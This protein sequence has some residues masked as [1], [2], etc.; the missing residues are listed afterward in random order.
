VDVEEEMAPPVIV[1]AELFSRLEVREN[2]DAL[3]MSGRRLGEGD[4][5]VYRAR[6]GVTL[7]PLDVG[8]G[9]EASVLVQPQ[10][11]GF[12]G[13][14]SGSL[15]DPAVGIHQAKM[16]I[17]R[18]LHW[19]DVGRFEMVYG[20]H[21][22]IGSV[23][24]HET[25]RSFDGARV[26]GAIGDSG[27]YVDAFATMLREGSALDATNPSYA[28]DV[29]FL[30]LYSGFGPALYEGL[31]ADAY[32]LL[33]IAA[34]SRDG[35]MPQDHTA[36]EATL[37]LRV[38]HQIG[39]VK[40]R[41]EAGLQIGE[42]AAG[43]NDVTAYHADAD[44]M[45][46]VVPMLSLGIGGLYA[47]GDDPTTSDLEGWNQL[48]PTAHKFL[49]LMD[50]MGARTNVASLVGK[51][52]AKPM[53]DLS[54]ALDLHVFSRPETSGG[55]DGYTG[56]ESDLWAKV[57]LGEGL[58]LSALYGLFVPNDTGPFVEDQT[59]HYGELQLR[60]TR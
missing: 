35:D 30:G 18:D 2:Y 39:P 4:N 50:V 28:G 49:G 53:E 36:T 8:R 58:T 33:N 14:T 60:Y 16:R 10:A 31:D 43:R 27:A 24:W 41:I 34:K 47:T 3:G 26:H 57:R 9:L 59:A 12:W 37:G 11:S 40:A 38:K 46:P 17:A 13:D 45:V 23:P 21:L 15:S 56:F 54:L 32:L 20:E 52:R 29:Y 51:A 55:I 48:F 42:R 6:L 44:A 7:P 1:G 25:G 19:L 5:V 22:V